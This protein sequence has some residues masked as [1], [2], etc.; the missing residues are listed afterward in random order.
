MLGITSE[1]FQSAQHAR[2]FNYIVDY[3]QQYRH[4]LTPEILRSMLIE[5]G[6]KDQAETDSV[7]LSS[8]ISLNENPE[9]IAI[10]CEKLYNYLFLK[11]YKKAMVDSIEDA[12]AGS[13]RHSVSKLRSELEALDKDPYGDVKIE[14][15]N[16]FEDTNYIRDEFLFRKNFPEKAMG[17]MSGITKI[18]SALLGFQPGR[19]VT[20][21]AGPGGYKSTM[22]FNL[23]Y[24][25]TTFSKKTIVYIN[26]EMAKIDLEFKVMSLAA[27]VS[28]KGLFA[29]SLE[30]EKIEKVKSEMQNWEEFAK[31]GID[32]HIINVAQTRKMKVRELKS[33][34]RNIMARKPIHA[35]FI[36]YLGLLDADR[37]S[38]E[39]RHMD[40]GNI[41][42]SLRGMANQMKFTLITAAQLKRSAIERL[43]RTKD[44]EPE[45]EDLEGSH[46]IYEDTDALFVIQKDNEDINKI[47]VYCCKN[48]QGEIVDKFTLYVDG[49]E[50]YIGATTDQPYDTGNIISD[51]DFNKA[52]C[53]G[54]DLNVNNK[55]SLS[56][57]NCFTPQTQNG[58]P[59]QQT[60]QDNIFIIPPNNVSHPEA[61]NPE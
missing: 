5:K 7:S 33:Q 9:N 51:S 59:V 31:Q 20:F 58:F 25:L 41:C 4:Q 23:A 43:K 19:M 52:I 3:Y 38:A 30:D 37:E 42:K 36:D 22:L 27:R 32:F 49:D 28:S 35:V 21:A 53:S 44:S 56:N 29:G 24:R 13:I 14:S 50:C 39:G 12:N 6:H 48:R 46:Q 55:I 34:L 15:V 16:L 47:H 57:I 10:L 26:L 18:D 11:K 60:Q 2:I 40:L 61:E 17:L 54:F 45:G 8:I 1:C